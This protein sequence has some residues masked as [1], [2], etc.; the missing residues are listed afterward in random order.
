MKIWYILIKCTQVCQHRQ[1]GVQGCPFGQMVMLHDP[2]FRMGLVS[3][4]V[5]IKEQV[6]TQRSRIVQT[7]NWQDC[8][9]QGFDCQIVIII[10]GR[11]LTRH[12]IMDIDHIRADEWP[13]IRRTTE[14][15]LVLEL[16][17]V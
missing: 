17:A 8:I 10:L 12:I 13:K 14:K 11:L 15:K 1:F 9:Q 7:D 4:I 6:I 5:N 16:T 2:Q 3:G